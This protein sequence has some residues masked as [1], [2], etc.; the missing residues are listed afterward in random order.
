VGERSFINQ[1]L[2]PLAECGGYSRNLAD[3]N[4]GEDDNS[5]VDYPITS[6][7]ANAGIGRTRCQ[8]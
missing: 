1:E 3:K 5:R 2:S 4:Q 6:V 7:A 8:N